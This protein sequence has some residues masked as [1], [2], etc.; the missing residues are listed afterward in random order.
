MI[1]DPRVLEENTSLKPRTLSDYTVG[2]DNNVGTDRSRRVDSCGRVN[3]NI[4]GNDGR[5]LRRV[6][7]F[8]RFLRGQVGEVE[9]SSS[10]VICTH[11][12]PQSAV[13]GRTTI[14]CI[15]YLWVDRYPSRNR[16]DP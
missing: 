15:A 2:T 4:S 13:L 11:Y 9:A 6:G 10:E 5:V 7:K 12:V 14:K 1:L 16:R 3:H 8:R